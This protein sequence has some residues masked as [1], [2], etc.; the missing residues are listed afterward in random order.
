MSPACTAASIEAKSLRKL[1]PV[2]ADVA[3]V[4]P[5]VVDEDVDNEIVPV[6]CVGAVLPTLENG[7]MSEVILLL[8]FTGHPCEERR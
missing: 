2:D 6:C 1:S 4:E 5:D 7:L 3:D 8:M